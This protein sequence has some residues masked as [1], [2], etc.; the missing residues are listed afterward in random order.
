MSNAPVKRRRGRPRLESNHAEFTR[1]EI[2]QAG[3]VLLTQQSIS[4]TGIDQVLKKVGISKGSFYH[5]FHNKEAFLIE[6]INEYSDYFSRRL[7]KHFKRPD[8][9]CQQALLGF[10][11]DAQ[12][13]MA[14][15]QFDRGCLVGNMGQ[16]ADALSENV[17]LQVESTLQRWQQALAQ[18]LRQAQQLGE[19]SAD[20]EPVLEAE[21]FWIGWEGAIMRAKLA[22]SSQPMVVFMHK[23]LANLGLAIKPN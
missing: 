11:A 18:R 2:I 22:R 4:A 1:Q 6:A 7:D 9:S 20:I 16:E 13:G 21:F 17:R 19:L 23:Y 5:Y 10:L 12:E 15:Y 8:Y 3:V 14:K